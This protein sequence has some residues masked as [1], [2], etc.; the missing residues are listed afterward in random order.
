[1]TTFS[2]KD[3][4]IGFYVEAAFPEDNTNI[5][6]GFYIN[7]R[8]L[9]SFTAEQEPEMIAFLEAWLNRHW[10][11]KWER[12]NNYT[13]PTYVIA[14]NKMTGMKAFEILPIQEDS[15][16]YERWKRG[17][18]TGPMNDENVIP[19]EGVKGYIL[20][21]VHIVYERE[22]RSSGGFKSGN[23]VTYVFSNGIEV[24]TE[25]LTPRQIGFIQEKLSLLGFVKCKQKTEDAVRYAA[26]DRNCD[27]TFKS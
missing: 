23:R 18:E 25:L 19:F 22:P 11:D 27:G 4:L 10:L 6:N 14:L 12:E 15:V 21:L 26:P 1:M 3:G 7:R 9:A 17:L 2:R 8:F 5:G 13:E 16:F 20:T 24:S